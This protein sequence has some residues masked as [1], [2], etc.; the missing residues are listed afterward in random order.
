MTDILIILAVLVLG[1]LL[2]VRFAPSDPADWHADPLTV[3]KPARPNHWLIRDGGD[4][5]A[6]LLPQPPDQVMARLDSIA[7]ATP[8]T[9]LLAGT[10]FHKTWRTRSATLGFPDYTSVRVE[11]AGAGTRLTLYA[12]A[13]FGSSDFGVNRKRAEGWIAQIAD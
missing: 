3:A 8:R 6:V 13:R 5:P 1:A 2:F 12:R 11:P 10:G 7:R 9:R 4:A